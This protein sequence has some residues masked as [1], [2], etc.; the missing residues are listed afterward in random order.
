MTIIKTIEELQGAIILLTVGFVIGFFSYLVDEH[1][2]I[3]A[4]MFCVVFFIFA[5]LMIHI[6]KAVDKYIDNKIKESK[7]IKCQ[8][9]T[10]K[11]I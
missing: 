11:N 4:F 9:T 3:Y 5:D 7:V 6:I 1:S 2:I 10:N 8:K